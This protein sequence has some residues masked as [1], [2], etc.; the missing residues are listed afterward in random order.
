MIRDEQLERD[1]DPGLRP[2]D[3]DPALGRDELVAEG[4]VACLR[5]H[6]ELALRPVAAPRG[7]VERRP[8]PDRLR[9]EGG[10]RPAQAFSVERRRDRRVVLRVEP[11]IH[12]GAEGV[13]VLVEERPVDVE[14]PPG[15]RRSVTVPLSEVGDLAGDRG[16]FGEPLRQVGVPEDIVLQQRRAGTVDDEDATVRTRHGRDRVEA[17]TEVAVR[18][19]LEVRVAAQHRRRRAGE[20]VRPRREVVADVPRLD[21]DAETVIDRAS[22]AGDQGRPVEDVRSVH[23]EH[24]GSG[25]QRPDGGVEAPDH[26]SAHRG[27]AGPRLVAPPFLAH[28]CSQRTHP[29]ECAAARPR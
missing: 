17:D 14:E 21:D 20:D 2:A 10:Q 25:R 3:E 6:A 19:R 29:A 27:V 23:G 11:A 8:G 26:R 12:V 9:G 1:L 5:V 28:I 7:G 13:A 24:R 15:G 4:G 22:K 18:D 16:G